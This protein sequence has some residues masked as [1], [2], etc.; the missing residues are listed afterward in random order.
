M[1]CGKLPI[2]IVQCIPGVISCLGRVAVIEHG[3]GFSQV[4][5]RHNVPALLK[6]GGLVGDPHLDTCD[7][8]IGS[9]HR[10]A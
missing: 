3:I 4:I 7:G 8:H 5:D 10:Q 6:V 9:N 2:G 1:G